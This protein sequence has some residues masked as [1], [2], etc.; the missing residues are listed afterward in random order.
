MAEEEKQTAEV[1]AEKDTSIDDLAEAMV[2]AGA[3]ANF[4]KN[5]N[6][7]KKGIVEQA[8]SGLAIL[9][10]GDFIREQSR[11]LIISGAV[12]FAAWVGSGLGGG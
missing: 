8:F 3:T 5:N 12:L 7:A 9:K 11:Y 4:V 6:A 1:E 10:S 2:K